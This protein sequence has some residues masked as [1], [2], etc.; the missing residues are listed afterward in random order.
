MALRF[1]SD[2]GH[3]WLRVELA[4]YP[5]AL[6][7]ATGYGYWA[8][9]ASEA[10]GGRGAIYLEEDVEASDFLDRHPEVRPEDIPSTYVDRFDRGRR[11]LPRNLTMDQYAARL[12][13]RRGAEARP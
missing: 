9:Q 7:S 10:T 6:E 8:G 4:E 3:G 11:P 12:K 5:D 1:V 2:P 13:A